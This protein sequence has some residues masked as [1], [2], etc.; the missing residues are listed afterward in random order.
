MQVQPV[1]YPNKQIKLPVIQLTH[2]MEDAVKMTGITKKLLS[3]LPSRHCPHKVENNI[4]IRF[5]FKKLNF[6][7][8]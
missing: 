1:V 8:S 5:C 2:L 3:F 4:N 6:P 7:G